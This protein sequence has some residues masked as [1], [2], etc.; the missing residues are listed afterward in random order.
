MDTALA[1]I[2]VETAATGPV[3]DGSARGQAA[4]PVAVRHDHI[5]YVEGLRALAALIVY[6]NHA[7]A[8]AFYHNLVFYHPD[9]LLWF[10]RFV[11]VTGHLSVTVFIVISGFV[12]TL[13]VVASGDQL[14]GGAK[15]FAKR[16][17]RRILPAYY[18]S[19]ALALGLIWTVMGT[20][21][22]TL[23]DVPI[24]VNLTSV[25]SHLLLLQDFFGTS[26]INYVLWSIAV[27]WHLYFLFPL[28]VWSWRRFGPYRTLG[29]AMLV[30]YTVLFV[31]GSTRIAR[32]NPHYL[33]MFV[34]GMFAA[35]VTRSP[36]ALYARLRD[37]FP[38]KW[39]ALAATA[40][41]ILL[42]V[43]WDVDLAT[44]RFVILDFPVGIMA[45]SLLVW[46]SQPDGAR[47][48]SALSW[49]PLVTVGTFSYSLY[50]IHAPLLQV[51]WQFVFQPAGP[52]RP[53]MFGLLMTVGLGAVLVA[54]YLFYRVFEAP[55]MRSAAAARVQKP[56]LQALA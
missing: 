51:L 7:Y 36:H 42:M 9:G 2:D 27:E 48:S 10:T 6:V 15:A 17:A 4:A 16:R 37:T 46:A 52:S 35:Y 18:G 28:L 40:T 3:P 44:E 31:F 43:R 34:L 20:P 41:T 5:R 22:G 50:L 1:T 26:K 21:T 19:L 32:A 39:S 29:V 55:F 30:G 53:M 23:W 38:W 14:R 8:Q 25:I 12:L 33:G 24:E 13:P 56:S 49:K 54:A 47:L 11:M 45:A